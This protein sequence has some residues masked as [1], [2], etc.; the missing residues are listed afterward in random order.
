MCP[1]HTDSG[2]SAVVVVGGNI[3]VLIVALGA[4]DG[5]RGLAVEAMKANLGE[6]IRSAHA[7]GA[8]VL[9]AGMEAPPNMGL[10]YT[11]E[12]RSAFGELAEEYDVAFLPFLLD[13]VAGRPELN[14]SDGIH[15]NIEG[16]AKIADLL[17]PTL[18]S[19]LDNRAIP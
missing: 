16:A 19:L 8:S 4:N 7:R 12:F 9:L 11:E 3:H 5:M 15:P 17:W 10:A 6:I 1:H 2:P 14:Q 18:E 13:G